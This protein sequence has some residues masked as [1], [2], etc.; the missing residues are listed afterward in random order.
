MTDDR[1][2]DAH[3]GPTASR[4]RVLTTVAL[5]PVLTGAVGAVPTT[6]AMAAGRPA[7]PVPTL[8]RPVMTELAD[9]SDVG[10]ALGAPGGMKRYM[11][12]TPLL[13]RD[14]HVVSRGIMVRPALALGTH[15]SFVRYADGS[16]L[17]MGDAVVTE[18]EL[19]PFSD[20]LHE[21]GIGQTAIHKHLLSQR[22]DIWWCHLHA[23]STDPVSVARGLRAALERTATPFRK[24]TTL[25]PGA[26]TA[27]AMPFGLDTAAIDAALGV[28]GSSDGGVY[29][30]T[31]VRRET[32]TDG[33]LVLPPGLGS[34][35][36]FNFQ[37][38]G[39]G[40]AAIS[41]DFAVIADEVHDVLAGL[42]HGGADLVELHHHNLTDE[43][44]L[45]FVHYWA[46]GDAVALAKG[47]RPVVDATNVEPMKGNG[48]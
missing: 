11:Y 39:R 7:E 28:K 8:V 23:H 37:P 14:L 27:F 33:H 19:Q 30:S 21:N 17:L 6:R 16:S 22:P 32:I 3:P 25:T 29:Q 15:L 1:Q 36:S 47:L 46:V 12:H 26:D 13:R 45:F 9:W 40:Q 18:G 5:A 4:R 38:L 24:T 42:R 34:T 31:F 43:P 41:G 44:R 35:T 2:Q 10:A 48:A 20:A